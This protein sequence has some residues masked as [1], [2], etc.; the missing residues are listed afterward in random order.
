M[1]IKFNKKRFSYNLP[2][3]IKNSRCQFISKKGWIIKIINEDQSEGYG[4]VSPLSGKDFKICKEQLTHIPLYSNKENIIDKI[5]GFHPC[6]KSAINC[7]LLEIEGILEFKKNYNLEGKD[8]T[9]T[10]FD[11]QYVLNEFKEF[12]SKNLEKGK[13]YTF[14]WKVGIYDNKVEEKVLEDILSILDSNIN[15]RLDANGAWDRKCAY[16]WSE[17]LKDI[18]NLDWLE[19][20]LNEDDIDGLIALN[21]KI[22]VA[23]DE[24][25]IKYPDLTKSWEG[26]QIRRPS[27]ESNPL[28]LIKELDNKKELISIS[29]SFETGIGRRIL[30]HCADKQLLVPNPKLP[31]LGLT[32]TPKGI[33]FSNNPK[34]IWESL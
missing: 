21:E 8:K 26:W 24:S 30:F 29:T 33:L 32:Y 10:L 15:F 4:E 17:I 25:L 19:Q 7:A 3:K 6:I 18:K 5:K 22:P 1:N 27:Q 23:L 14:K 2:K 34:L 31:G 16:R 20:P 11:S 28:K 13:Q 12:K 9:A